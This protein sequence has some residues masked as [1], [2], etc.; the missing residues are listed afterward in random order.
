MGIAPLDARPESP[1]SS[2]QMS[3]G[4]KRCGV[5]MLTYKENNVPEGV[6]ECSSDIRNDVRCILMLSVPNHAN[7]S[8]KGSCQ[9]L[10]S[11][12]FCSEDPRYCISD[13]LGLHVLLFIFAG[14]SRI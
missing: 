2:G 5:T 6:W 9:S 4:A 3:P 1:A 14:V 7:S 11:F 8:I 13:L 12:D 10:A